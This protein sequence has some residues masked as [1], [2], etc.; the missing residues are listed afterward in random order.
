MGWINLILSYLLT[1]FVGLQAGL[2]FNANRHHPLDLHHDCPL[3]GSSTTSLSSKDWSPRTISAHSEGPLWNSTST[4][5]LAAG[6]TLVDRFQFIKLFDVGAPLQP[7]TKGSTSVLMLYSGDLSLPDGNA[8]GSVSLSATKP[9]M[10]ARGA[11]ANCRQVKHIVANLGSDG[12]NRHSCTAFVGQSDSYH[13][14]KWVWKDET[15]AWEHDGRYRAYG[16]TTTSLLRTVPHYTK[17]E[18]AFVVLQKYLAA[19]DEA[20]EELRPIAKRVAEAGNDVTRGS[21]IVMVC[22]FGHSE[23]FV[24]FVCSARAIGMDLSKVLMFAT[25][26]ETFALA[27]SLGIA[28]FHH[29]GVFGSIPKQASRNYGD[30]QYAQIMMSKVYCVHLVSQLGYHMFFQDVSSRH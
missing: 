6:A 22:N 1:A 30:A 26:E 7:P 28:A 11:V 2:F 9:T 5:R 25:D 3:T 12:R 13:I 23:V 17:T 14:N 29:K 15:N 16:D 19:F 8:P 21:I 18:S 27:Q 20:L 4:F 10:S 24:N